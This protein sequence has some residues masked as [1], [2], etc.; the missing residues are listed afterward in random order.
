MFLKGLCVSSFKAGRKIRPWQEYHAFGG[1]LR[2]M[3]Y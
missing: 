3:E 1:H 2:D